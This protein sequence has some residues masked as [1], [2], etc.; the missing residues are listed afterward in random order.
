LI[1]ATLFLA[2]T[3]LL[4]LVNKRTILRSL[5]QILNNMLLHLEYIVVVTLASSA[6]GVSL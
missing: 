1:V 5:L 2:W 3:I 6:S 4:E